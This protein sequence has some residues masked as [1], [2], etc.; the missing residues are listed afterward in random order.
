MPNTNIGKIFEAE[1]KASIPSDFFVERYKDD[2][3]GLYGVNNPADFRL[4]KYPFTFLW[5]L[6]SHRG[7]SVPLAKIRNSQLIGMEKAN[8]Y[9]GVCCGFLLN[10]RDL[11]ETYY[12][13]FSELISAYYIKNEA[14]EFAPIDKKSISVEWCREYGT[15]IAQRK[16]RVRYA[17]DIYNWI[18]SYY[19]E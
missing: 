4:Y 13:S 16:K 2:M 14:G 3:S 12:I 7:K 6:K 15:R 1:I 11:E 18:K 17:Y 10:F 9:A 5:E 19:F 8:M